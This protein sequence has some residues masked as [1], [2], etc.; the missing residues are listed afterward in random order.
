MHRLPITWLRRQLFEL[1]QVRRRFRQQPIPKRRNLRQRRSR[2]GADDPV[3]LGHG[4]GFWEGHHEPAIDQIPSRQC[5]ARKRNALPVD[6]GID[7]HA[8]PIEHRTVGDACVIYANAAQP[9]LPIGTAVEMDQ[10]ILQNIGSSAKA[11]STGQELCAAY[12]KEPFGAKPDSIETWPIAIA[13]THS[14]INFFAREI[15]VMQGRG[16]SKVNSRMSLGKMA[17]PMDQP[18]GCEIRRGTN[19]QNARALSLQ[20][21]LRARGNTIE[22]IAHDNEVVP[23]C[24][25]DDKPLAFAI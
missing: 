20:Q 19:R 10:G 1:P 24:F 11:P 21:T 22:R 8:G 16:D 3:G 12:G 18:F 4:K 5:G 2:L 17:Q 13:V 25:G 6:C 15:D 14:E 7:H 9:F 23:P